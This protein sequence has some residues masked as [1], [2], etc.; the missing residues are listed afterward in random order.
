MDLKLIEGAV[1]Q[2]NAPEKISE[3]KPDIIILN[4][5]ILPMIE[6][7]LFDLMEHMEKVSK[8]KANSYFVVAV[9]GVDDIEN[10]FV[11]QLELPQM[12]SE[13]RSYHK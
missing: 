12:N 5:D 13:M 2:N 9:L 4:L 6:G 7:K 3:F 10:T 11:S 1:T 8:T